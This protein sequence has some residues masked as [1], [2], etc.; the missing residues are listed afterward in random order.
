MAEFITKGGAKPIHIERFVVTCDELAHY[1]E[2]EVL[3]LPIKAE[4][5]T[6]HGVSGG[7]FVVMDI[8]IDDADLT[9]APV[10]GNYV[11]TFLSKNSA[12]VLFKKDVLDAI[13]PFMFPEDYSRII[14]DP[15]KMKQL[16]DVGIL[17]AT[18]THIRQHCRFRKSE[19][20]NMW[21]IALNTENLIR[22]YFANPTTGKVE[23]E[24]II[25]SVTGERSPEIQWLVEINRDN[26]RS[27][28]SAVTI[29][30]IF[31]SIR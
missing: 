1:L 11:E 29:D 12:G 30:A 2:R 7:C 9:A 31:K 18:L 25:K 16:S 5:V 13:A 26:V 19:T 22:D 23:G 8:A 6:T 4:F 10:T 24:L 3:G 20:H 14:T 27:L 21:A 28:D 17:G 15:M